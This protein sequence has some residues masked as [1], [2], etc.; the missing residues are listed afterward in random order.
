MKPNCK[1]CRWRPE[2]I[3]RFESPQLEPTPFGIPKQHPY[4]DDEYFCSHFD[5]LPDE[6]HCR[7]CEHSY[8]EDNTNILCL[9]NPLDKN[10][11]DS[12][13]YVKIGNLVCSHWK[14]DWKEETP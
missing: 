3:C 10:N 14:P 1:G 7:N 13:I 5:P 12:V 8:I 11:D 2:G 4:P 6:K 9:L